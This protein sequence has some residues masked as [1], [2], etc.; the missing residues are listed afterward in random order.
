MQTR[1]IKSIDDLEDLL[2]YRE[3]VLM[4]LSEVEHRIKIIEWHLL[5][6]PESNQIFLL[7]GERGHRYPGGFLQLLITPGR[8]I[9]NHNSNARCSDLQIYP[10]YDMKKFITWQLNLPQT[11]AFMAMTRSAH[12][13]LMQFPELCE[14][15]LREYRLGVKVEVVNKRPSL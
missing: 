15:Y 1:E 2:D 6:K 12:S 14:D 11:L 13:E 7:Y 3:D 10:D 9:Y 8:G 5:I 4:P